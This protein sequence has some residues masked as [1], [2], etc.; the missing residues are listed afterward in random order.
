MIL[1]HFHNLAYSKTVIRKVWNSHSSS[2]SLSQVLG[3]S[4]LSSDFR[5]AILSVSSHIEPE[6]YQQ[7]VGHPDWERAMTDKLEALEHNGTWS[8]VNLPPGKHVVGC[9]WVYKV[10]HKVDDSVEH[11]KV[12][13]WL[14]ATHNK[15]ALTTLIP[16]LLLQRWT[17]FNLIVSLATCFGW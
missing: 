17:L 12:V 8:V 2:Y 16:F 9:K 4:K 10:K 15:M 13:W 6:T 5:T 1:N 7:A 11:Y 3:Y 14:R